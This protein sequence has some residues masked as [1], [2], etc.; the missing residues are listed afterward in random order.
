MVP[1]NAAIV[2]A[3]LSPYHG[4][5]QTIL[6]MS[7]LYRGRTPG[8]TISMRTYKMNYSK[9]FPSCHTPLSLRS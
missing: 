4:R 9:M 3:R 8:L 5:S 6:M 1:D 2:Q 7:S